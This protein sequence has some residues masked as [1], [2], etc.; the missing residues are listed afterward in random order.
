MNELND[1]MAVELREQM[2]G[3][4]RSRLAGAAISV[5]EAL[6]EARKI[7]ISYGV[8]DAEIDSWGGFPPPAD[9]EGPMAV[10]ARALA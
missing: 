5:A 3:E 6:I 9:D 8:W 2:Y 7:G 1:E 10:F 4:I